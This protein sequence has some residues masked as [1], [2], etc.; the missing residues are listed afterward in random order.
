MGTE[1]ERALDDFVPRWLADDWPCGSGH[2]QDV[3][4]LSEIHEAIRYLET[5][6]ARG[7]IVITIPRSSLPLDRVPPSGC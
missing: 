6:Q 1:L 3:P 5:G 2:R 7:K 4:S